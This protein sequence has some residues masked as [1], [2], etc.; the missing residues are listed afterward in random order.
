MSEEQGTPVEE[1]V[2]T[3]F[4]P[5]PAP[6]HEQ[7]TPPAQTEAPSDETPDISEA[8]N[9]LNQRIAG[10]ETAVQRPAEQVDPWGVLSE[11][12]EYEEP[13]QPAPQGD[14][15]Q[16]TESEALVQEFQA[17]V[18]E[19]VEQVLAPRFEAEAEA[20]RA[21]GIRALAQEY[22]DFA[23]PEVLNPIAAEMEQLAQ[24]HGVPALRTDPRLARRLYQAYKA[25]AVA[26]A[27]TPAEAV[28]PG[29]TLETGAGPG[30]GGEEPSYQER[31]LGALNLG[32]GHKDVFT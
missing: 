3:A 27:E 28:S 26:D 11:E 9:Q 29:A 23:T 2:T 6:E 12:T 31:Y 10:I 5:P 17:L 21:E 7:L 30:S 32:G 4:T 19:R 20:K 22:P 14:G 15:Q 16:L 24:E 1:A 25:Q 8:L 18:D 13:V